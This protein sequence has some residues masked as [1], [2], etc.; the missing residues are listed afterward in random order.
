MA[1]QAPK[2]YHA[3]RLAFGSLK[4]TAR[5]RAQYFLHV[6]SQELT[7]EASTIVDETVKFSHVALLG[8]SKVDKAGGKHV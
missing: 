3:E 6:F 1:A 8:W 5:Q 4:E 7:E 2:A